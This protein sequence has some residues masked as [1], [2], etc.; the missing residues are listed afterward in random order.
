M[1]NWISIMDV[2]EKMFDILGALDGKWGDGTRPKDLYKL[3]I[4]GSPASYVEIIIRGLDSDKKKVRSGSAELASLHS[5]EHPDVLYPHIQL[6]IDNLASREPVLRWE[7]VC[8]LG[9]LARVDRCQN[10]PL[11]IPIIIPFLSDK[12]IVLQ[13]HTIRALAKIAKQCPDHA[14]LILD[15]LMESAEFLPGNRVGFLI[16]AMEYFADNREM[17]EKAQKFVLQLMESDIKVVS[18]KARKTMKKLCG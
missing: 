1:D 17:N 3:H 13:G 8:T 9:N 5:E 15:S 18:R 6:F 10:L 11:V 14:S 16:E 2:C 7:A 4:S 12:S